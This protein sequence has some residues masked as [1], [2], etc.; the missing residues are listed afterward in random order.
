MSPSSVATK[1]LVFWT[2]FQ[3]LTFVCMQTKW[4]RQVCQWF[5]AK[6]LK[7]WLHFECDNDCLQWKFLRFEEHNDF[8]WSWN[9]CLHAEGFKGNKWHQVEML[10]MKHNQLWDLRCHCHTQGVHFCSR[11]N[12]SHSTCEWWDM[13]NLLLWII[14]T[15]KGLVFICAWM[16]VI[17]FFNSFLADDRTKMHV[18]QW[19]MTAVWF[20]TKDKG[21]C[22]WKRRLFCNQPWMKRDQLWDIRPH[23]NVNTKQLKKL[24]NAGLQHMHFKHRLMCSATSWSRGWVVLSPQKGFPALLNHH[25]CHNRKLQKQGSQ[26]WQW[27]LPGDCHGHES[28]PHPASNLPICVSGWFFCFQNLDVMLEGRQKKDVAVG[29]QQRKSSPVTL[30]S[31]V[32]A[33][34]FSKPNPREARSPWAS[35]S[36]LTMTL[37]N[38]LGTILKNDQGDKQFLKKERRLEFW[39]QRDDR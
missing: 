36:G 25:V 15:L 5:T 13:Q 6:L 38:V 20:Q 8:V 27:S 18:H 22:V 1:L 14:V 30:A 26:W 2:H 39:G 35:P 28:C 23:T 31:F 29:L 33:P 21:S 24:L 10:Q 7:F 16:K 9:S 32:A 34:P 17:V 12:E 37:T 4:A 11:M 3:M 19:T